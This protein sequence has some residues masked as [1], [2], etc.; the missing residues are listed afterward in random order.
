M[1]NTWDDFV[2]DLSGVPVAVRQTSTKPRETFPCGECAGSGKWSGGTNKHGNSNCIACKGV[3][4]F[5][6]SATERYK[7]RTARRANKVSALN[8]GIDLF[9]AAHPEMYTALKDAA[10]FGSRNSF[11]LSLADQL[12]TRGG[13]SDRQVAAWVSGNE[14][15]QAAKAARA[16]ELAAAPVVDLTPIRTMF[17]TA[18][19]SGYKRPTY[20]AEG[21]VISRAPDHGNNPGA[22][23]VKDAEGNYRGKVIGVKFAPAFNAPKDV[24]DCLVAIATD[25]LG[26]ALRYGQRTGACACCG[27][28]LTAHS[29][30][31]L[32]IGP[33]CKEKWGL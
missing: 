22:L 11:L 29:S 30:I 8:K 9:R 12:F 25:P 7:D 17:E 27:R 33:V 18:V 13:L 4:F 1:E 16:A 15:I 14:K 19:V 10:T 6:K 28:K 20:R 32:G 26:A 23:Y 21:L 2:K 31:D 5:Y 24:L 3:G